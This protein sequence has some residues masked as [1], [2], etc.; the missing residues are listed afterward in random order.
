MSHQRDAGYEDG[1]ATNPEDQ[2]HSLEGTHPDY[3]IGFVVGVADRY[4]VEK[5]S[6][7]AAGEKAAE[8]CRALQVPA[9]D[10]REQLNDDG[11][12]AAFD[13]KINE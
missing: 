7:S 2:L 9:D 3:K 8:L 6:P 13:Q 4:S 12:R 11:A 1:Q 5:S 10:V